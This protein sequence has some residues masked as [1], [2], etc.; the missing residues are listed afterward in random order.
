VHSDNASVSRVVI[1]R[2]GKW[3]L[4]SF[5]DTSHLSVRTGPAG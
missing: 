4:R 5:N 2:S 3:Q 1:R